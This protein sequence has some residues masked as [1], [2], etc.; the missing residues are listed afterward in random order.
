MS[1]KP[2]SISQNLAFRLSFDTYALA[3]Q[4]VRVGCAARTCWCF[5]AYALLIQCVRVS[6]LTRTGQLTNAYALDYRRARVDLLVRT[7][8]VH[9]AYALRGMAAVWS[10]GMCMF[11]TFRNDMSQET[12]IV[13]GYNEGTPLT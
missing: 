12:F 2:Y 1:G 6:N 5:D 3:V 13:Q 4:R 11:P 9:T 7:Q 8:F 10:R